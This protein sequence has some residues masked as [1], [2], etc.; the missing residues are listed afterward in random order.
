M[1]AAP[2]HSTLM[3]MIVVAVIGIII[4]VVALAIVQNVIIIWEKGV[5]HLKDGG[6]KLATRARAIV[7]KKKKKTKARDDS[8][9]D[10]ADDENSLV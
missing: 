3:E 5:D 6:E 10:E 4:T 9:S 1:Q 7:A 8:T 2:T